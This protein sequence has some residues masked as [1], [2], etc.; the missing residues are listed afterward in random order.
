MPKLWPYELIRELLTR[1]DLTG[2]SSATLA[3]PRDA[4]LFRYAI[5]SFRKQTDLGRDLFITLEDNT[6][7]VAKRAVPEILI[8]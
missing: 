5:Y 8:R 1:A 3:S 6:V 7:K 4:Q 2:E